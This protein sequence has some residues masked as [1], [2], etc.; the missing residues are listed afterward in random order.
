VFS[1]ANFKYKLI[2]I[3]DVCFVNYC[4]SFLLNWRIFWNVCFVSFCLPVSPFV[5]QRT[6]GWRPLFYAQL[7]LRLVCFLSPCEVLVTSEPFIWTHV[8]GRLMFW[9]FQFANYTSRD[10]GNTGKGFLRLQLINQRG[11][12]S[13][14]LFSGGLS[15]VCTKCSFIC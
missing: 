8:E 13:F 14:A 12:F 4:T 7:L 11:D 1:P 2:H 6:N 5:H 15:N 10:Y 3:S 9:Q